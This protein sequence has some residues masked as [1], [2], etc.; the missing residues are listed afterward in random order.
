[1]REKS[2][3]TTIVPIVREGRGCALRRPQ[4]PPAPI[5][6]VRRAPP[7]R[8]RRSAPVSAGTPHILS[9]AVPAATAVSASAYAYPL[10]HRRLLYLL[11]SILFALAFGVW[12]VAISVEYIG[13]SPPQERKAVGL[14]L[15][16]PPAVPT[17]A[18]AQE[19]VLSKA[20]RSR[21]LSA[22]AE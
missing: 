16:N 14:S 22:D 7:L 17:T 13:R 21:R 9:S 18:A 1:V 11:M 15:E 12:S 3:S 10:P 19:I 8:V 2:P 5:G 20:D 4:P 6:P